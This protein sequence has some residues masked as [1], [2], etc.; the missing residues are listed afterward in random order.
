MFANLIYNWIL[1][2]SSI[3]LGKVCPL[4]FISLYCLDDFRV[5]DKYVL[6]I[7]LNGPSPLHHDSASTMT[8]VFDGLLVSLSSVP[9]PSTTQDPSFPPL[10]VSC[11]LTPTHLI[12]IR[13]RKSSPN[14]LSNSRPQVRKITFPVS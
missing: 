12:S 1:Y 6:L 8:P 2:L 3:F 5:L 7:Q 14:S 9:H 13:P 10:S 4:L 11:A